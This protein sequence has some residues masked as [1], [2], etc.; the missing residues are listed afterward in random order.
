MASPSIG[1]IRAVRTG[2][3]ELFDSPISVGSEFTDC[4]LIE[5]TPLKKRM[6]CAFENEEPWVFETDTEEEEPGFTTRAPTP[7]KPWSK[8][9]RTG[10]WGETA[11]VTIYIIDV[12]K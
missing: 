3:Q 11:P 1:H 6:A 8:K 10:G 12:T 2:V 9:G 7:M 5:E 4:T